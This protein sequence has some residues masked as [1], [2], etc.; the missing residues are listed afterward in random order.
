[1]NSIMLDSPV[2]FHD[3]LYSYEFIDRMKISVDPDQL[4]SEE[5]S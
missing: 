5:A 1:M 4:A 2:S 3:S